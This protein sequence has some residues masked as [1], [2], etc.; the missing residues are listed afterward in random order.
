MSEARDSSLV[1]GDSP[2]RLI[3]ISR[4][5]ADSGRDLGQVL[6]VHHLQVPQINHISGISTLISEI[7][8]CIKAHFVRDDPKIYLISGKTI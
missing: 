5:H 4:R 7:F 1:L 2:G 6:Q 8:Y 3:R